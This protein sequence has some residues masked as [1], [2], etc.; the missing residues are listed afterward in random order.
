MSDTAIK[1][2]NVSKTFKLPHEKHSSVKSVLLSTFKGKRSYEKQEVLKNISFEIIKGEFFGIVGRNGSGKS[3]LLKLLAG[4]YTPDKGAIHVEGKLTPFIELGVGFNP[5]LTG[6]ENVYLNG[7]LLGF[8]RKEMIAMYNEI[9]EFAELENFMDQK[10]KNYSSGMQVRLAFSIAIRAKS[11]ILLI[12][13]VL[14]VGDAV[15]QKKCYD[16]FSQLKKE[17]KTVIF[18]SHD[19]DSLQ[20]YCDRGLLIDR[21]KMITIDKISHVVNE[22]LDILN[23]DEDIKE[24]AELKKKKRW[25]TGQ[26]EINKVETLDQSG[27]KKTIFDDSDE[28]IIIK[29]EHNPKQ[30]V[31]SPVYGVII[32]DDEDNRI[33]ISNTLLQKVKTKKIHKDEK[34]Y[35]EWQIPNVF[36]T[37]TFYVAPAV[38]NKDGSVIFDWIEESVK[39][40]VRKQVVVPAFINVKHGIS[41]KSVQKAT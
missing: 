28:I 14:A 21:G 22:Y 25:G 9:V 36:N 29:L 6:R 1:V 10:L 16:Y 31:E 17:K 5:E 27:K 19:S 40:R 20:K 18:V 39:F 3:T 41:I 37:G 35:V 32:T 24:M 13:E 23:N 34:L 33:F 26:V 4:I 8:N 11:D 15:F 12:D 2:D 7:A 30:D 38:A